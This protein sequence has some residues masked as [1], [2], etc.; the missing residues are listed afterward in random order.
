VSAILLGS[1]AFLARYNGQDTGSASSLAIPTGTTVRFAHIGDF[2]SGS[3][4]ESRVANLVKGWNP[5]FVVTDGD[6]NYPNGEASTIDQNIGQFYQ[7]YIGNYKGSYGPGSATNRFWPALGN[8]DWDVGDQPY[9]AYFTLPNNERYYNVVFGGGLVQLFVIDSDGHEPDGNTSTSTQAT[10]LKNAL[11]ASTACFKLV[12]FHHPPY[13]TWSS[14]STTVMRWPFPSW[15]ADMVLA[16]HAHVYERLDASGFPYIVN[17]LGG[18]DL[19]SFG[20]ALPAGVTSVVRY[21][22]DF[23][24]MLV[25][26][27]TSGITYQFYSAGGKLIDTYTQAKDCT[28]TGGSPVASLSPTSLTFPSQTVGTTS[29][30][31]AVNLSNSGSAAL[32]I[33]SI[34]ITGTNSGDFA[35]TNNC[36]SSVAAGSSCTINLTF[37]PT[38]TGTRSATLTVTDNASDSPQTASVTGTGTSSPV[39]LSPAS[40][41]FGN[42]VVNTTSAAQAVTLTNSG[43]SALTITSIAITGTNSGDFA[44]NNNCPLSPSTL[45]AGAKCTINAT[46][47]PSATGTRSA[48]LTV[49]D[50][51]TG[52]PQTVALS[53]TGITGGGTLPRFGHVA[54]V[55]ETHYGYSS[56]V[57]STS[58]PYVNSLISQYGLA[59]N[60]VADTTPAIDDY[61]MLAAGKFE[62][63]NDDSLNCTTTTGVVSDDNIVRELVNAG[64]TWKAYMESIPSTGYTGCSSGNYLKYH[65]PFAYLTDVANVPAQAANMVDFT[66]NFA[67]D[68]AKGTLPQYSFIVP[69]TLDDAHDGT[70]AQADTWLQ[71]NI[72]PLVQSALFQ[73]D[74]LLIILFDYD[75]NATS[76]CTMTQVQSGTWCGGQVAAVVVSP[77][78]VSAG[79]KSTFS[80][81]HENVLRLMAQGLGLTTLPGISSTAANMSDFF[82]AGPPPVSLSPTSLTFGSQ[83]VGTTSAS[84][85]LTLSNPGSTALSITSIAVGGDFAQTNTCGSSVAAASSCTISVTFTPTATGTRAGTLTV[86]DS[87]TSSPQTASLTG[88]GVSGS[89][90]SLSPTS[91]TFGSQNVGTTSAAQPMTLSNPGS[92]ALSVTSIALTGTNSGDFAQ[93]NTCGT[94]VAAA[95]SCTINVTFKPTATGTRTATLTVTDSAS[96]S[97]QSASLTGSGVTVSLSPTSLT[98]G[99]QNVGT[100]SAAQVATLSNPG[101]TALSITSIAVTGTN[102]G[103]FAIPTKTCGAS[104]PAGGNCTI[105]VTF[106]PTAAGTRTA[107]LSVTDSASNSPQ[108]T[109][110]TGTGT[111]AVGPGLA[112]VQVQ[113]NIDVSGAALTSFSVNITT[114]PGDLLVAFVRESSNGTDNFTVTDSAGQSWTQTASG[115][116]NESNTGPRTGMFYMA[117]SAAVTSVTV[118]YTTSGGVSKPGIMVME[119]SGGATSGVADGSVN[120]ATFAD[121]TGSTS[122]SLTTT[123]ANDILIFATDTSGN[124]I[125]WTAG[126]GYAIPNNM[127]TT[128]AS[129]SDVRMAMQ[130]AVVSSVQTNTAT[131]TAYTNPNWNGNTFAAFK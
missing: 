103:D 48:T 57:G 52:S 9:L 96:N 18:E 86:T 97:P 35:Q 119:I 20:S 49:S 124:E 71:T 51:A 14:G 7:S 130:Y 87:A 83:N 55:V 78:L 89:T 5:D 88:S 73:K 123:N 39:S 68:L 84:Q 92:T 6:N 69:N 104:V 77:F 38:A 112:F 93:T 21:N 22:L 30:A 24:A 110:V 105:N 8:H 34:A 3:S 129:G 114:N 72:G 54:V 58:M 117:N 131:S 75:Q 108:T 59:T 19:A 122:G 60:Y 82:A 90:A 12:D 43:S 17:G 42:Q 62:A 15:G 111:T 76:G 16:G 64:K 67:T 1:L 102:S 116:N 81:H 74:G 61:F 106:T 40:L 36:G 85:P 37:K 125:G 107:T 13:T 101:S 109:S 127:V 115:Y 66:N 63:G 47:T 94:S 27:N 80:Y 65:N 25:T 98:F 95:S 126:A 44:Q 121:A 45:A 31:Q 41:S 128:G 10:W 120:R 26:A 118:R 28:G 33:T 2:G 32:S 100:T 29:A 99:S 50:N 11:A 70:L 46:F 53:G 91:L 4:S 23:G 79:Y 56:V 113:N